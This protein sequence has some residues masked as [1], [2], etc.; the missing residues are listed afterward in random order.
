MKYKHHILH[1]NIL[2][3]ARF[4]LSHFGYPAATISLYV[5]SEDLS[6]FCFIARKVGSFLVLHTT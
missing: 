3:A 6:T 1:I 2:P 5:H 4:C